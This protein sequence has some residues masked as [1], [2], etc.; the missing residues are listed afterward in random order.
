[1]LRPDF[2]TFTGADDKTQIGD[3]VMLAGEF[4]V[5][6]GILFSRKRE[7]DARYPSKNWVNLLRGRGLPLAAHVCG[8]YAEEIVRTGDSEL[9]HVLARFDRVQVNT[10]APVDLDLMA[11]FGAKLSR[12]A[13]DHVP[14]ILQTRSEI[15]EDDRFHWLFDASGGRGV[16][17]PAWPL[18]PRKRSVR[19]GYAGGLGPDNVEEVLA[20]LPGNRPAWI[21]METRIRNASDEFDIGLCRDVCRKAFGE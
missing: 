12:R 1:M 19:F 10:A 7:G 18:P 11:E 14:I 5:E 15:P 13:G 2:I 4:P 9:K 16:T 3:L 21:D 20:V 8:S 6:F 17:P